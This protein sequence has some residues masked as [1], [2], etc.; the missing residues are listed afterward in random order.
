MKARNKFLIVG[1]RL[2]ESATN[3]MFKCGDHQ[4]SHIFLSCPFWD[5]NLHW[6]FLLG[7]ARLSMPF[8]RRLAIEMETVQCHFALP[9]TVQLFPLAYLHWNVLPGPRDGDGELG[10]VGGVDVDLEARL[11]VH[12]H[13]LQVV[14]GHGHLA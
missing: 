5:S 3:E 2:N 14:Q 4:V 9:C 8:Q 7:G 11:L 10:V 12:A 1:K 6:N 13:Q